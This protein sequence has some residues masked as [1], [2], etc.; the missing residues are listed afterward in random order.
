M[1][2]IPPARLAAALGVKPAA[3]SPGGKTDGRSVVKAK[4]WNPA[5]HTQRWAGRG[6]PP[7]WYA[8][9]LAAGRPEADLRIPEGAV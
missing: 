1:L 7:K 4:F 5:D 9:H 8:A 2:G 6:A 3:R